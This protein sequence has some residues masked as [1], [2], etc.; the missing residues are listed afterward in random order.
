MTPSEKTKERSV[1]ISL[2]AVVSWLPLIPVFWFVVKPL[3]VTAVSEAVADDVKTQVQEGVKPINSAFKLLLQS[4]INKLK[5]DIALLEF[6]EEHNPDDWG[7]EAAILLSD[8][9]IELRALEEA[10]EEL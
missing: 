4:D 8:K 6:R 1:S 2:A 7:E 5:R 3:L 9:K 10:K